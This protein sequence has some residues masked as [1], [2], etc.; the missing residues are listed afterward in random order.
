M[1]QH[2]EHDIGIAALQGFVDFLDPMHEFQD[3]AVGEYL[4]ASSQSCHVKEIG[5]DRANGAVGDARFH[6]LLCRS[7]ERLGKE[8]RDLTGVL[9][10]AVAHQRRQQAVE[11]GI[12]EEGSDDAGEVTPELL[13]GADVKRKEPVELV[14]GLCGIPLGKREQEAVFAAEII[15]YQRNIHLRMGGNIAERYVDRLPLAHDGARGLKEQ[16]PGRRPLGSGARL[17][18][19]LSPHRRLLD[20]VPISI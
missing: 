5:I 10:R 8:S 20:S 13:G 14:Q 3:G 19:F 4:F 16:F 6:H 9:F 11:I 12:A 17:P 18:L 7:R 1:H 15:A 2:F